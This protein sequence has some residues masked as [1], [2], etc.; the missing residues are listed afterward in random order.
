MRSRRR[1]AETVRAALELW[2]DLCESPT[3]SVAVGLRWIVAAWLIFTL[4]VNVAVKGL[5]TAETIAA[6]PRRFASWE[7][8]AHQVFPYFLF[9]RGVIDERLM[10]VHIGA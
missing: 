7:V 1:H 5:L 8:R 10:Y 3:S 4:N 6:V 9:V 2:A